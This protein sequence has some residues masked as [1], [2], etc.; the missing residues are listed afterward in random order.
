M[1]G[2]VS[3]GQYRAH[4]QIDYL[5]RQFLYQFLE[6]P[7]TTESTGFTGLHP[8]FKLTGE[9]LGIVRLS[10]VRLQKAGLVTVERMAGQVFRPS[11]GVMKIPKSDMQGSGLRSATQ[12]WLAALLW[13]PSLLP[14]ELYTD[15]RGALRPAGSVQSLGIK[16]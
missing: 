2:R 11:R 13:H 7:S 5:V 10:A 6:K 9:K 14:N 3:L 4:H 16:L 8:L 15:F 12:C 1:D